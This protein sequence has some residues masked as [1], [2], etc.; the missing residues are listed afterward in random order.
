MRVGEVII[1]GNRKRVCE[2]SEGIE[3]G[4]ADFEV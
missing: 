2:G 3:L 4:S 1:E